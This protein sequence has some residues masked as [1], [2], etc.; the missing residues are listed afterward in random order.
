P[1]C[2]APTNLAAD[3]I[4]FTSADL[5]WSGNGGDYEFEWGLSGFTQGTGTMIS[6]ATSPVELTG[7]TGQTSYQFYVREYCGVDDGYSTWAGPFTFY[8][9]YC[10]ATT[11]YTYQYE[12]IKSFT[13]TM[14][15]TNISNN[16]G[17]NSY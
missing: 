7:L 16:T 13:T 11:Q 1:S 5:S 2:P 9:D 4:T 15:I 12:S 6:P 3:N 17:D 14:A 8:T 10:E